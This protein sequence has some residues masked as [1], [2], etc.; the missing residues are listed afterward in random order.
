MTHSRQKAMI[1]SHTMLSSNQR[2]NDRRQ[3]DGH[4][5]P[6]DDDEREIGHALSS[7]NWIFVSLLHCAQ[8][9]AQSSGGAC[10]ADQCLRAA[11]LRCKPYRCQN[12]LAA[13]VPIVFLYNSGNQVWLSLRIASTFSRSSSLAH[14]SSPNCRS[15]LA[16]IRFRCF[17][18]ILVA[19]WM[20]A[21]GSPCL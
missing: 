14:P 9:N 11:C 18:G 12:H 13:F 10:R 1:I 20:A 5:P 16:M 21:S 8:T 19:F 17:I 6:A 15:C 2:D 4:D 7:F 3:R